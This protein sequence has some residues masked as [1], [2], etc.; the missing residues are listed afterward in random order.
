[1]PSMLPRSQSMMI[2]DE[3]LGSI[4]EALDSR[5]FRAALQERLAVLEAISSNSEKIGVHVS[6]LTLAVCAGMVNAVAF[7]KFA[8]Y[9]SHVSGSS[10]AIGLRQFGDQPG[11]VPTPALLV[12]DFIIGSTLC[13]L[14]IPKATL[15][16]GKAPYSSALMMLALIMASPIV[17]RGHGILGAHLLALGCGLQNGLCSSWSGN[18]IRTTHMTGTGTDLGL[19]IGR[20]IARFLTKRTNF[21]PEDW[22]EHTA[23]RNKVIPLA[24]RGA[25]PSSPCRIH[26]GRVLGLHR[27][28]RLRDLDAP[29][30]RGPVLRPRPRARHLRSL[31]GGGGE[32]VGGPGVAVRAAAERGQRVRAAEERPEQPFQAPRRHQGGGGHA[33]G[34]SVASAR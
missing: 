28:Q 21:T 1:M 5:H 20:I 4:G 34:R 6:G 19:A 30:A 27:L 17:L 7:A 25:H 15:K 24:S 8:T 29:D 2:S 3:A 16:I 23:D 14:L 18:V 13:G 12:L 22:E 31:S 26:R 33:P 9:V 11:D 32:A 10:T